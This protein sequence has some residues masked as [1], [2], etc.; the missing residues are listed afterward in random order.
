LRNGRFKG[1][2]PKHAT[3]QIVNANWQIKTRSW[4]ELSQQFRFLLNYFSF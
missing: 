2:S 4:V 3:I 1:R